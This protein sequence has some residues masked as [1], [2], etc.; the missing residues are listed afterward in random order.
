MVGEEL[1]R[2][3]RAKESLKRRSATLFQSLDNCPS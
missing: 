1:G 2:G 3:E